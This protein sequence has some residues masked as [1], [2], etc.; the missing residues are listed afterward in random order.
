M[1]EAD[2]QEVKTSG[3]EKQLLPASY[4]LLPSVASWLALLTRYIGTKIFR[5][6]VFIIRPAQ[7]YYGCLYFFRSASYFRPPDSGMRLIS[8]GEATF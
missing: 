6:P 1:R 4:S 3:V 2:D 7:V 5:A 8:N